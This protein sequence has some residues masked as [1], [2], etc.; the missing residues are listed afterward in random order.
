MYNCVYIEFRRPVEENFF[1]QTAESNEE[2]NNDGYTI[3]DSFKTGL[4]KF[5]EVDY[6]QSSI[7]MVA[8]LPLGSEAVCFLMPANGT[9]NARVLYCISTRL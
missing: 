5:T 4:D 6:S 8:M 7:I 1:L 9:N 2:R 3:L